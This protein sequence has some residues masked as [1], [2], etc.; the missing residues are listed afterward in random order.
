MKDLYPAFDDTRESDSDDDLGSLAIKVWY[1]DP[2]PR[3]E[4]ADWI[5]L[6]VDVNGVC[7]LPRGRAA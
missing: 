4:R 7:R 6:G 3:R 5:G 1:N 2:P